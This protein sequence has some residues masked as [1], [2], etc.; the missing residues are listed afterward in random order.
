MVTSRSTTSTVENDEELRWDMLL[1]N[2]GT[3]PDKIVRDYSSA[4]ADSCDS[5]MTGTAVQ[6]PAVKPGTH[7]CTAHSGRLVASKS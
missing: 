1:E 4:S 2:L 5:A 3:R 7:S 6:K